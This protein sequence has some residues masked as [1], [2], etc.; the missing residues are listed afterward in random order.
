MIQ[1][2]QREF[3]IN[4]IVDKMTKYLM[5]DYGLDMPAALKTVYESAIFEKLHDEELELHAQSPSYLYEF[6]KRE[7]S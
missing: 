7:I 2:N 4:H 5:D 3:L 6:L 1:S